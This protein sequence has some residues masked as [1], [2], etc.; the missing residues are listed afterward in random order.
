MNFSLQ[1]S[2]DFCQLYPSL[3]RGRLKTN[4]EELY[5]SV[6]SEPPIYHAYF[7][8]CSGQSMTNIKHERLESEFEVK[9]RGAQKPHFKNQ[10]SST[11][12]SSSAMVKMHT[13][14]PFYFVST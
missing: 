14:Y 6:A 13:T 9:H 2:N 1:D 10:G 5:Y 12:S 4:I 7:G 11:F 3:K 8:V